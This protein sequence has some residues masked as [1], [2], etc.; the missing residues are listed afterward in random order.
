MRMDTRHYKLL[1]M[2]YSFGI[3]VLIT[4]AII[5]LPKILNASDNFQS[6]SSGLVVVTIFFALAAFLLLS[7]FFLSLT[8]VKIREKRILQYMDLLWELHFERYS[9]IFALS[10]RNL[11]D[12]A[13]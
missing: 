9:R 10:S 12:A 4:I 2:I 3:L 13:Q 11:N 6:I 7:L 8:N 1:M 5:T